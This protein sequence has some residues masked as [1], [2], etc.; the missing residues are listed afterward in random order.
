M[1]ALGW[2][3]AGA[4]MNQCV[5]TGTRLTLG[6]NTCLMTPPPRTRLDRIETAMAGS[7][8]CAV[9]LVLWEIPR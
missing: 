5:A 8:W 1:R 9:L 6:P 7:A 4:H 3:A 2:S